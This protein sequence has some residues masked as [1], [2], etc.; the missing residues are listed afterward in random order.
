MRREDGGTDAH[1]YRTHNVASGD[2]TALAGLGGGRDAE[3]SCEAVWRF[4]LGRDVVADP[5]S[6]PHPCRLSSKRM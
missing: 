4:R 6:P 5:P 3:M 1:T 2:V